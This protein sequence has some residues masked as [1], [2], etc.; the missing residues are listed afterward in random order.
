MMC[1]MA[2][3]SG[4][5]VVLNLYGNDYEFH[6]GI[7]DPAQ[8]AAIMAI[9]Y[10]IER[11][12]PLDLEFIRII[13]SELDSSSE[14]NPTYVVELNFRNSFPGY[15]VELNTGKVSWLYEKIAELS[16]IE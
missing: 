5:K 9:N 4:Y 1:T 13:S 8:S 12:S 10:H 3:V 7:L 6:A 16:L 14:M 11:R 2:L 15:S